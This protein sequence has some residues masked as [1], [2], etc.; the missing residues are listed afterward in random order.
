MKKESHQP[1]WILYLAGVLL[2]LTLFSVHLTSGLYARY[3]TTSSGSDGARVARFSIEQSGELAEL[4]EVDVY[5][6]FTSRSYEVALKNDSEVAVDYTV[7]VERLTNNLPL[8]V[9][10]TGSSVSADA[11]SAVLASGTMEANSGETVSYGLQI[12]WTGDNDEALS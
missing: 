8:S 5:P 1:N 9:V 12:Q 3:S 10:L 2:C 7:S 11:Y 6:G 4:I